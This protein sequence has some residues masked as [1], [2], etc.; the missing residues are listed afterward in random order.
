MSGEG[1][2][3]GRGGSGGGEEVTSGSGEEGRRCRERGGGVRHRLKR[4]P[5]GCCG[6]N[7]GRER[8]LALSFAEACGVR[9]GGEDGGLSFSVGG[10]QGLHDQLL[11]LGHRVLCPLQGEEERDEGL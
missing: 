8:H 6:D 9:G 7:G 4:R 1:G 5:A 3:H 11:G 2:H 10:T